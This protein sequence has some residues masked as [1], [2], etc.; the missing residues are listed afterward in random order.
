LHH[1]IFKLTD[2]SGSKKLEGKFEMLVP[3]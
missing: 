3:L 2:L 1:L